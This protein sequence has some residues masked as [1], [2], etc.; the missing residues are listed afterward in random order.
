MPV[1]T[2]FQ[3]LIM[4]EISTIANDTLPLAPPVTP[5]IDTP[6]L[7]TIIFGILATLLAIPNIFMVIQVCRKKRRRRNGDLE[8]QTPTMIECVLC[9]QRQSMFSQQT[10]IPLVDRPTSNDTVSRLPYHAD[11]RRGSSMSRRGSGLSRRDLATGT[12]RTPYLRERRTFHASPQYNQIAGKRPRRMDL[13][14]NN[15]IASISQDRLTVSA[16]FAPTTAAL[17]LPPPAYCANPGQ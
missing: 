5:R 2:S 17:T 13:N 9:R 15:S 3:P 4:S 10:D 1:H 11:H 14:N 12:R 16:A 8:V 7:L 6:N